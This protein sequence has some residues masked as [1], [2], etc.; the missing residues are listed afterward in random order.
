[1]A[2]YKRP[3]VRLVFEAEEFDGLEVECRR[4]SNNR[5]FDIMEAAEAMDALKS[6]DIPGMRKAMADL[7]GVLAPII[8]SWNLDDDDDQPVPPT[9]DGLMDQDPGLLMALA[10]GV[11]Q[12]MGGV[13]VPLDDGSTSGTLSLAALTNMDDG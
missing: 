11:Q 12:A 9:R 5:M 3:S 7:A 13:P 2:R 1:M 4:V 8:I 10:A 6:D